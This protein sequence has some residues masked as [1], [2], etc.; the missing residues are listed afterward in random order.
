MCAWKKGE[1]MRKYYLRTLCKLKILCNR[2]TRVNKVVDEKAD[3]GFSLNKLIL[4]ISFLS[5]PYYITKNSN[6]AIGI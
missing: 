2:E 6:R 3:E 5:F 4:Q 1:E